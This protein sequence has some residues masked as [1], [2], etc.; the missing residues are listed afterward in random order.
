VKM[1]L[2]KEK[3]ALIT[4]GTRGI[5]RAIALSLAQNGV[6]KII[7]N[8]LQ[9]DA[10]AKITA[11]KINQFNVKFILAKANIL[12]PEEIDKLFELVTSNTD[13]INIFIHCAALNAFKPLKDI[14]PNQWDLTMNINAR[15][16]LYCVQQCLP[17]MPKGSSIVA[18]SSLGGQRVIPDYGAM[19]PTKA[20][21]ET[22]I[23]YLAAELA[24]SGIRV[25][26]VSAGLIETE[27]IK[28]FPGHDNL[29]KKVLEKT[30]ANRLGTPDDIAQAVLF[31]ISSAADFIYG[32]TI[33][34]DGGYSLC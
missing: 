26:A 15:S 18:I 27:S 23:K 34:V 7:A 33:I 32:Q 31:L 21:L 19:G 22:T 13:H 3:V 25:N 14:K 12:Y 11:N 17:M 4:G 10:E 1:N 24:G 2:S 30:P 29:I 20:A 9:N 16:F 6:D 8:Y 5:G 28:K